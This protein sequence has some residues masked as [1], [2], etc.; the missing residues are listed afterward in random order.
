MKYQMKKES[1]KIS[2]FSFTNL[3]GILVICVAFLA[4]NLLI[5]LKTSLMLT[6]QKQKPGPFLAFLMAKHLD[7]FYFQVLL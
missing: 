3:T 7:G 1:E 6:P 2:A 4:F 5:S